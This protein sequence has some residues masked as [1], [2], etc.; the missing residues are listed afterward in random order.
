MTPIFALAALLL[1]GPTPS[2]AGERIA[3]PD[4]PPDRKPAV[5]RQ[6]VDRRRVGD[7][8]AEQA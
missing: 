5:A 7:A 3:R 6:P 8:L 1:A 4:P 2:P